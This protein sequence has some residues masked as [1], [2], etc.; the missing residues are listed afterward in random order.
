MSVAHLHVFFYAPSLSLDCFYLKIAALDQWTTHVGQEGEGE[1]VVRSFKKCFRLLRG[2]THDEKC[3]GACGSGAICLALEVGLVFTSGNCNRESVYVSGDLSRDV[4]GIF[5]SPSMNLNLELHGLLMSHFCL[6]AMFND[7]L[8]RA[9]S[10]T[11]KSA[12]HGSS[13]AK[14]RQSFGHFQLSSEQTRSLQSDLDDIFRRSDTLLGK[15]ADGDEPTKL[16]S[17]LFFSRKGIT[18]S[19]VDRATAP[20]D[21]AIDMDQPSVSGLGTASART[22]GDK[23]DPSLMHLIKDTVERTNLEAERTFLNQK[24]V[25]D[26]TLSSLYARK[27][28]GS[29]VAGNKSRRQ[30]ANTNVFSKDML[31]FARRV[32]KMVSEGNSLKPA[33]SYFADLC[34]QLE[35]SDSQKVWEKVLAMLSTNVALNEENMTPE[36]LR[37]SDVWLQH[38]TGSTLPYLQKQYELHMER[39]V[40]RNLEKAKRGGVPGVLSLVDAYLNVK[41]SN[42]GGSRAQDARYGAHPAWCVLFHC[43][44]TGEFQAVKTVAETLRNN[45]SCAVVVNIMLNAHKNEKLTED[46][47]TK[48]VSEWQYESMTCTDLYKKAVYCAA[49]GLECPEINESLEDWLWSRLVFTRI[50]GQ[51]TL[52]TLKSLQTL[53]SHDCGEDYFMGAEGNWHLYFTALWLTGQFERAIE[54]LVR[55]E[56]ITLAVHAAIIGIK[57]KVLDVVEDVKQPLIVINERDYSK[58]KINFARVM[59]LY[60]KNFEIPNPD[61]AL[62]YYYFLNK[63]KL[64]LDK[65]GNL[66]E[67]CVS[68]IVHISGQTSEILGTFDEDGNRQHGLIDRYSGIDVG[69]VIA[70]V[71][72]DTNINGDPLQAVELFILAEKTDDALKLLCK[73]IGTRMLERGPGYEQAIKLAMEIAVLHRE[74]RIAHPASMSNLAT[75]HLMIDFSTFFKLCKEERNSDALDVI[76]RLEIV[77]LD[78]NEVA[79]YV[80]GFQLIPDE[81]RHCLPDLCIE[82]M[83]VL[84]EEFENN[85]DRD[86]EKFR[87]A[88]KAVILYTAM[89]PYRFPAYM[90]TKLLELQSKIN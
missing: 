48:L 5:S 52:E 64:P 68:R 54:L 26:P 41:G 12:G 11:N 6:L 18:I 60:V 57:N 7:L 35:T 51:F 27:I 74:G 44:R 10:L 85:A 2:E 72:A 42:T 28:Y 82:T 62:D 46:M 75:L 29:T 40:Q 36:A 15:P 70:R 47:R 66:F 3:L 89:V 22:L 25:D 63:M 20:R 16:Q 8:Y 45:P 80:S 13:A 37:E 59:L 43:L 9:D 73:H 14:A 65:S 71:A 31:L 1:G 83:R 32:Q 56:N 24:V 53:I 67:A 49:L 69:E 19:S 33:E 17:N 30:A 55:K 39:V 84:V 81:V 21:Q 76:R 88:A 50:E 61:V 23:L 34:T 86:I 58:A 78:S 79:N 87:D 90:N 38:L 4:Y 77:P